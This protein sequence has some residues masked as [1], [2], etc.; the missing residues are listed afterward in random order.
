MKRLVKIL[1][2]ILTSILVLGS[3]K[4]VEASN[5]NFNAIV[6]NS[7]VKAG[8][9]IIIDLNI[10]DINA[11]KEGINVVEGILEYDDSVFESIKI[12]N[13]NE[14]NMTY[15]EEIGERKGKFLSAKIVEGVTQE[16]KIGQIQLKIKDNIGEIE[17][18]IKINKIKSN[19][20]KEL[21]DEGN[22][23]IKI[24]IIKSNNQNKSNGSIQEKPTYVMYDEEKGYPEN[25]K[26]SIIA[27]TVNTGDAIMLIIVSAIAIFLVNITYFFIK[28]N[29][30]KEQGKEKYRNSI[31]IATIISII[32]MGI[33]IFL[34]K[35]V[36]A[37]DN[38][39]IQE[40]IEK[41][42]KENEDNPASDS[43]LVT[44]TTISRIKP[45][46]TIELLQGKLENTTIVTQEN[47][48][49]EEVKNKTEKVK[50]GMMAKYKENDKMYKVSV[51]GDINGDGELNQIEL[52]KDIREYLKIEDWRITDEVERISADVTC[53]KNID[54]KDIDS[55]IKY[56][57]FGKLEIEEI[58]QI[59]EPEIQIIQ[60][61]ETETKGWYNSNVKVKIKEQNE[62]QKTE[63]TIYKITGT[64]EQEYKEIDKETEIELED[65]G[66]YKIT[67]YTYG[68]LGNKSKGTTAIIVIMGT[69]IINVNP[70]DW[71]NQKVEISMKSD[72]DKYGVEYRIEYRINEG[73]WSTYADKLQIEENCKIEARITDGINHGTVVTKE[74]TNIDK[75]MPIGKIE[76]LGVSV[77]KV[78]LQLEGQD[79]LSGIKEIKV[80]AKEE[81]EENYECKEIIEY[82][83]DGTEHV[84]KIKE[85]VV[86]N[87]KSGTTYKMFLE[88]TDIAGNILRPSIIKDGEN[89]PED[90]IT[91]QINE[92][93]E[94]E[95]KKETEEQIE[96]STQNNE[97]EPTEENKD[98]LEQVE[99]L[100]EKPELQ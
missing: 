37:N 49:I 85:V 20:G 29:K 28:G 11:G 17:T 51:L 13:S 21:I 77:S 3:L 34:S 60:G 10:S 97:E 46:T 59:K 45:E 2:L 16:E 30:L 56:I 18:E 93:V 7:E 92:K 66:V 70:V 9:I 84:K 6:N 99:E 31:I 83:Q 90:K 12:E 40:M 52:T 69:P 19:D 24:K 79:S 33:V 63:K 62:E 96:Y 78:S 94:E 81:N 41:L 61:N 36:I 95:I 87:L 100:T 53:D 38:L 89:G 39:Y 26:K 5:F 15:N 67:A 80:Y 76:T 64:K 14:W 43:Y 86:N 50:T 32:L 73:Q 88:V 48:K 65:E 35:D 74:V 22:R 55:I 57:V 42:K 1:F 23:I 98:Y 72:T 25:S 58:E 44:D 27:D 82:E 68:V 47:E 91:D 71:T 54:T 75:I 4:K 8:E